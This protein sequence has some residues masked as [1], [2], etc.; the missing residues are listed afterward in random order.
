MAID[1]ICRHEVDPGKAA[2][3]HEYQETT[4]YF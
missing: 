1:P 3:T 4:Y 2:A